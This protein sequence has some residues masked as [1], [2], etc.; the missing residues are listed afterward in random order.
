MFVLLGVALAVF[1]SYRCYQYFLYPLFFSPLSKIPSAHFTASW[2][3]LWM[4]WVRYNSREN[5]AV[6]N[7]HLKYGPIVR[8]GPNEI[9]V[10]CVDGGIRT[11]YSGGFEKPDFYP[12]Q[13]Q[14]FG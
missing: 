4:L 5:R 10:N 11:V 2:S 1:L 7:A 9:S 14:N 6:H 8:L 13:F 12:N 3:P